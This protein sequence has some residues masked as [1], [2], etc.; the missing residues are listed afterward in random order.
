[1]ASAHV[2]VNSTF[3]PMTP[4]IRH[5]TA[6]HDGL[7]DPFKV[8]LCGNDARHTVAFNFLRTKEERAALNIG[9]RDRYI[10]ANT[11]IRVICSSDYDCV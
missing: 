7:M 4:S 11:H 8:I 10:N 2:Y 9:D 5:A 3:E 1:M 6:L